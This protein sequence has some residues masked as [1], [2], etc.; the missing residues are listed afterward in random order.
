MLTAD[1]HAWQECTG[2]VLARNDMQGK[3]KL[4]VYGCVVIAAQGVLASWSVDGCDS[5]RSCQGQ[6]ALVSKLID[7][8]DPDD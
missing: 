3:A 4:C 2:G 6:S 5:C 8:D 1:V 7:D